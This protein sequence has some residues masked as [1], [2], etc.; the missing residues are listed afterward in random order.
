MLPPKDQINE[1]FISNRKWLK[2]NEEKFL[3]PYLSIG[4][5]LCM[6]LYDCMSV[7]IQYIIINTQSLIVTLV[8]VYW[9]NFVHFYLCL[10]DGW[11]CINLRNT[12]IWVIGVLLLLDLI[13]LHQ[14]SCDKW[15]V[16]ERVSVMFCVLYQ[17]YCSMIYIQ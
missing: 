8:S 4:I 14:N 13:V 3:S 12:G 16:K 6:C 5:R 9:N 1:H 17:F 11:K 2:S 7:C 15:K 10:W